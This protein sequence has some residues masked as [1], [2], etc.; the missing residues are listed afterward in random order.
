MSTTPQAEEGGGLGDQDAGVVG[1]TFVHDVEEQHV[2]R[3]QGLLC[4]YE[5][6]RA[7]RSIPE[8]LLYLLNHPKLAVCNK[9][10]QCIAFNTVYYL[11]ASRVS[12]CMDNFNRIKRVLDERRINIWC[13]HEAVGSLTNSDAFMNLIR[14]A[15]DEAKSSGFRVACTWKRPERKKSRFHKWCVPDNERLKVFVDR[16][17]TP[18]RYRMKRGTTFMINWKVLIQAKFP[19]REENDVKAQY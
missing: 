14:K 1:H 4:F 18:P 13:I 19:G 9:E 8:T 15:Q 12:R 5:A 16:D 17:R 11:Y 7:Y 10:G 6:H 3:V 2:I